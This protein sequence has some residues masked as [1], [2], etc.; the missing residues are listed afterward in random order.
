MAG[1]DEDED[2]DLKDIAASEYSP[3]PPTLPTYHP[4]ILS[5]YHPAIHH[6]SADVIQKVPRT[7]I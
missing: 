6:S 4:T 5:S 7:T 3:L 1:Q 2:D